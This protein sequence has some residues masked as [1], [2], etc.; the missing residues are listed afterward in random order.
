MLSL[1]IVELLLVKEGTSST[2]ILNSGPGSPI[3]NDW[4]AFSSV[5]DDGAVEIRCVSYEKGDRGD[6]KDDCEAERGLV[7]VRNGGC[8][9]KG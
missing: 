9:E 4:N 2:D 1:V 5:T 6:G 3:N 7:G 8:R